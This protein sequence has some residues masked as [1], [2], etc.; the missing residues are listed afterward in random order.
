MGCGAGQRRFKCKCGR[1]V[2]RVSEK[3]TSA[4]ERLACQCLSCVGCVFSQSGQQR[5]VGG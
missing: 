4:S 2:C 1:Y 5:V 3:V